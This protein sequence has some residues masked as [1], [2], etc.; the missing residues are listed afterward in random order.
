M[1]VLHL[2]ETTGP[3]GAETVFV[4]LAEGLQRLGHRSFPV[5]HGPGWVQDALQAA[6]F[7]ATPRPLGRTPDLAFI[8]AMRR[9]VRDERITIIQTHLLGSA[10]YGALIGRITRIPVVSTF[11]GVNDLGRP[12]LAASARLGAVRFG[13]A[14]AVFVSQGLKRALS[15]AFRMREE[16]TAVIYN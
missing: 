9:L 10:A 13:A 4:E 5:V 14:R 15:P 3:G 7:A 2:I 12:G 6:G 16:R 8:R 1:N 11:H